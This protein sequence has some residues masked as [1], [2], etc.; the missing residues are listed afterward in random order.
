[1]KAT[2]LPEE[3]ELQWVARAQNG[4]RQAFGELVYH[5]R[6]GVINVVYR[7]CGD[8]NLAEDAAQEAFIRAWQHLPRYQPRSPF[9]NWLYR[10]AT[11]I[12]M[13]VL[14]RERETSDIEDV[15]LAASS[16]D[17][18]TAVERNER[19]DRVRQAVLALA[20]ASRAVLILREYEDLSYK[21][22]AETLDIPVGTVMSRLNYARTQ[23]R[24]T[25]RVCLED[26]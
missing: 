20:P 14:R 7:M 11:N 19:A 4:D 23:L 10:I 13:D 6:E 17:P 24:E 2:A 18:E 5:Y 15:P 21:E 8:A 25:L 26:G 9:R 1:V 22:I 16:L 3:T 12:A